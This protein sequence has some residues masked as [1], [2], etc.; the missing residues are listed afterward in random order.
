MPTVAN[1]ATHAPGLHRL[2]KAAGGV[3]QDR[4]VPRFARQT[5]VDWF[6]AHPPRHPDGPPVLLWPD[7]FTNYFSPEVGRD[8]VD[9]LEAAG[10][11]VLLPPGR[12][13]CCGRPLYDY[14]MLKLAR[15]YLRR[16]LT[17]LGPTLH[18]GVPLVGLEPSCLTV[19]RDELTN[20]YPHDTD[21]Q[22]LKDQSFTLSEFLKNQD[23]G[24]PLP[25][26][27]R[28]AL[29]QPHC[30][31]QSVLGF[32]AEQDVL[33]AMGVRVEMAEAGCCGMAGSFG[34]EAG[35]RYRVSKA[36]GE[37]VLLPKVRA[38]DR[39]TLVL[40]DGFS[41]RGQISGGS[42]RSALH[43]AQVIAMAIRDGQQ[44]RPA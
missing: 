34:Y 43:L 8:A 2:V 42:D 22:R 30:H 13:L 44:G 10:R 35:E 25:R 38:A 41:C 33:A 40:A 18:Q 5:F 39:G 6:A 27:D 24:W 26:L 12:G 21:A 1:A 3:A 11:R 36:A 4:D 28:A 20:L 16:V 29:V 7:T 15:R 23:D 14:G 31:H 9:V 19:F 37:R 17:A 32:D